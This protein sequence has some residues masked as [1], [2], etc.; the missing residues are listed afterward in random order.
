MGESSGLDFR[1]SDRDREGRQ[2]AQL[3]VLRS[4][5]SSF[6]IAAEPGQKSQPAALPICRAE[7]LTSSG[8]GAQLAVLPDL[9]P[10][11]MSHTSHEDHLWLPRQGS[12]CATP[13]NCC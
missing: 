3:P 11:P 2:G 13:H 5:W 10:Q 1:E 4:R 12:K 6:L 9:G 7:L 8:Q